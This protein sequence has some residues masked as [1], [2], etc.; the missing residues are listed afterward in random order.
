MSNVDVKIYEVIVKPG[1]N[2]DKIAKAQAST[3]DTLRKFN[4][5][6]AV[7]RPGQTLKYQKASVQRVITSWRQISTTL[8]AQRYNGGRDINYATKLDYVLKAMQKGTAAV[9]AE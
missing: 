5:T 7:L 6:A 1:D 2:L 4:P 3:V 8:I 9:C